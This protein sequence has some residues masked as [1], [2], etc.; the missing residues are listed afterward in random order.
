MLRIIPTR[1]IDRL[2]SPPETSVELL[3]T[4]ACPLC[5]TGI[6]RAS[7]GFPWQ[8]RRCGQRWSPRRLATV[9]A[10]EAWANARERDGEGAVSPDETHILPLPVAV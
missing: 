1:D 7:A 9:A 4:A 5:H 8:C 2:A 6:S 10:Y 3:G